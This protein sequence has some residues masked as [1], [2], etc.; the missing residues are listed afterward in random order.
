MKQMFEQFFDKYPVP[1][2]NNRIPTTK[3]KI[4]AQ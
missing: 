1:D 4:L 3:M 2:N